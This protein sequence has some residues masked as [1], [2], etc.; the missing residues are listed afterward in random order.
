MI[1]SCSGMIGIFVK[2]SFDKSSKTI[3]HNNI[4][5]TNIISIFIFVSSTQKAFIFDKVKNGFA[6]GYYSTNV[7]H[8]SIVSL[9]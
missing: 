1:V 9:S 6:I 2:F 4:C 8:S 5:L 7:S 3:L